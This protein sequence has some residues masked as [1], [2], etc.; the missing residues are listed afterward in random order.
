MCGLLADSKER[1]T[2]E[3][4]E[5]G[6]VIGF[7]IGFERGL[8]EG[9]ERRAIMTITNLVCDEIFGLEEAIDYF[10]IPLDRRD[11]VRERVVENLSRSD[12]DSLA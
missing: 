4:F 10:E 7:V 6:F 1:Y 2:K 11:Y 9:D 3:G 12:A 5:I 8:V